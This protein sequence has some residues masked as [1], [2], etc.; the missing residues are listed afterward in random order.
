MVWEREEV[1]RRIKCL[2]YKSARGRFPSVISAVLAVQ[3]EFV[4]FDRLFPV[5]SISF[6]G[7]LSLEYHVYYSSCAFRS[8]QHET[9]H[10]LRA[11][12]PSKHKIIPYVDGTIHCPRDAA[13]DGPPHS[14]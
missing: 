10:S 4:R 7:L 2:S 13:R 3:V 1:S 9:P 12:V 5:R 6:K 14:L 8:P 11:Q